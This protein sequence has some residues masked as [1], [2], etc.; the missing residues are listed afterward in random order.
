MYTRYKNPNI[1][2]AERHLAAL[3]QAERA[4][5]FASGM[6]AIHG[7]FR[8]VFP[9]GR[10]KLALAQQIYG[11]TVALLGGL[12]EEMGL[13]TVLFDVTSEESLAAALA[14]SPGLVHVEGISNPVS[15]VADLER[16]ARQAHGAGVLL[17]VDS[18][19]ATPICQRPLQFGADYV[20]H[21]ATKALSGHSDV[22]AGVV[23]GSAA[24]LAP[25]AYARKVAGAILDPAAAWLLSR[26]LATLDLRVRAQCRGALV[27]SEALEGVSGVALVH[28]PGLRNHR[29]HELSARMLEPG[30]FGSVLAFELEAGD[31]ATRDYVARLRLGVDAPSLG[32]VETL[33]SIPAV[34]SHVGFTAEE[35]QAA[36]IGP[37]CIRVATG[38]EDPIDLVNDFLQALEPGARAAT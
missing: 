18:T 34:M 29:S 10:G 26:S 16:I 35:R 4:V 2:D 36:G 38:I 22:T 9:K 27:L 3:E 21:S 24:R 28:Y 6:A 5:L 15:I 20:V 14:Q 12:L 13:E 30:L 1:E 33:V 32:G 31:A 17:S 8:A 25:V 11:G 19:F 37:G 7:V 23:L